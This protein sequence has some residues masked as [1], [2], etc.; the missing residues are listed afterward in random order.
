MTLQFI[1]AIM[2]LVVL[3]I[4]PVA[5]KFI[6]FA[7]TKIT[8]IPLYIQLLWKIYK[9]ENIEGEAR[10][11]LTTA[12]L[13]IGN[14]L[15]FLVSS[16]IP[17]TGVPI[18]G[19]F[20]TPI[21]GAIALVVSLVTLDIVLELH[22]DY[23]TQQY[24]EEFT[25]IYADR[26]EL[27][28]NLGP[29]WEKMVK[30]TQKILDQ[31][32]STL[33]PQKDY[34]STI[35]ALINALLAYLKTPSGNESLSPGEIQLRIVKEGLPP[36]AKI[37]GSFAEGAAAGVVAGAGVHG[38]AASVF[39]QAG[40]L[41]SIKA[42]IGLGGGIA[43]SASAYSLLTLAAPLTIAAI[44]GVGVSQ[45]AL[46]LRNQNEK[47]NLSKFLGDVLIAA[48]PMAWVDGELSAQEKDT[49]ETL[50][51]NGAINDK[52][53][54]RVREALN[55]TPNF[56]E[57]LCQGLLKEEKPEKA[58]IKHRLLLTTAWEFAKSDGRITPEE[59]EL[60]NRIAKLTKVSPEEVEEIRRLVFLKS[61]INFADRL[62]LIW[63]N[64]EE[65]SVEAIVCSSNPT[66]L[67]HK[68]FGL[69]MSS[70]N[71][72]KVDGA[73]HQSAGAEMEKECRALQ[74][75]EIGEAKLTPGYKL[76]AP[77]V[78]HT[79]TPIWREGQGQE[80]ELL[81][82]CYRNCLNLARK[83][84]LKSI[85]FPALGT[86]TGQFPLE[87]AAQIAISEI[88]QFLSI[89]FQVEQVVLVCQDDQTYKVYGQMLEDMVH[90]LSGQYLPST[91]LCQGQSVT[92]VVG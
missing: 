15:A 75:C 37:G 87:I 17:L 50:C 20:T 33:D 34:D 12:L 2:Q 43:V 47:R 59:V 19:A 24:Q 89:Y 73:I 72:S 61:G 42:A 41:T 77:W 21:A 88:K 31:V 52:D 6:T 63:G 56:D 49:L 8:K 4:V 82:N 16:Y 28:Q 26:N 46:F 90:S 18:I 9:D 85:A 57:I 27:V 58:E 38:A 32:K 29:S 62:S 25:T 79:V 1:P 23:L 39:V 14:I 54:K 68:K 5:G 70:S 55:K 84:H 67:P 7:M 80:E 22:R 92:D 60:H 78:I 35:V 86:G 69:F 10:K 71:R 83:Q 81:A 76:P 44:T 48:L 45:G 3:V 36:V 74:S 53:T 40:F 11:Y 66:L 30:E 51:L 13:I 91:N 64:I 65:Q